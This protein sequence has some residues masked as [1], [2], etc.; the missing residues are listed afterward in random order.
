MVFFI[1]GTK[2][3][4]QAEVNVIAFRAYPFTLIT[5]IKRAK[6]KTLLHATF[7]S[8][9]IVISLAT[10]DSAMR[11]TGVTAH[12]ARNPWCIPGPVVSTCSL[13]RDKDEK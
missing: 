13:C 6:K 3:N 8:S 7:R 10:W 1:W 2:Y 11:D 9:T 5:N 4:P 12:M